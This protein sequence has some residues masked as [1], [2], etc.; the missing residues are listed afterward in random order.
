MKYKDMINLQSYS[1]KTNGIKVT[2]TPIFLPEQ[3]LPFKNIYV[4]A[5]NVLLENESET[6]VQLLARHWNIVDSD[7][8]IM[9][10]SG[11]GVIGTQPIIASGEVY[12]YS[13]STF[14]K[15]ASGLMY[16]TYKMI[17]VESRREF[18][19]EIPAFSLDSP[20]D[21]HKPD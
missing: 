19:I 13:S 5:Y 9:Q 18:E 10:A 3:S 17:E 16:G 15:S 12:E 4:W 21:H 20:F 7:G 2:T 14:L 1:K 11:Q 8:G 6:A